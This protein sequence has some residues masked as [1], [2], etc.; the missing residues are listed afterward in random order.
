MT[1]KIYWM[2]VLPDADVDVDGGQQ[3]LRAKFA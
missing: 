2:Q 1:D 3:Y